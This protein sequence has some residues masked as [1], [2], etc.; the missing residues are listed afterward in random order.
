MTKKSTYTGHSRFHTYMITLHNYAGRK[1]ALY[2]ITTTLLFAPLA[3]AR[4]V[5][6]NI[7]DS[8]LVVVRHTMNQMS[9]Q[10]L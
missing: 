10:W 2:A 6:E 1:R 8:N 4:H 3:K 5:I 7:K 9:T